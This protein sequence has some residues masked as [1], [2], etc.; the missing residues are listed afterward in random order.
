MRLRNL[1]TKLLISPRNR[2]FRVEFNPFM[3]DDLLAGLVRHWRQHGLFRLVNHRP[4]H[5]HVMKQFRKDWIIQPGVPDEIG[6]A[7]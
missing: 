2:K 5:V 3:A 4:A 1:A 7:G 6:Y